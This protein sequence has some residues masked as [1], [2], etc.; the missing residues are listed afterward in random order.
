MNQFDNRLQITARIRVIIISCIFF[1]IMILVMGFILKNS[2]SI[3]QYNV[4]LWCRIIDC[5][6]IN[7]P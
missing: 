2:P 1:K 7:E 4:N 5:D 6:N 3:I